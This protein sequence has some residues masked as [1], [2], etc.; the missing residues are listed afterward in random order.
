MRLNRLETLQEL[1]LYLLGYRDIDR[2]IVK[3][4]IPKHILIKLEDKLDLT[5]DES[6][7]MENAT[8]IDSYTWL[9]ERKHDTR[10]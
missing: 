4:N 5:Y 6:I 10:P 8:G 1:S 3:F 7:L 9:K 2:F